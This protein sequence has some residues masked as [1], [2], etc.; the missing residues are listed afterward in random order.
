[1]VDGRKTFVGSPR[2]LVAFSGMGTPNIFETRA[3]HRLRFV[4]YLTPASDPTGADSLFGGDL[5][6]PSVMESASRNRV[7]GRT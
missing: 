5:C 6:V 3:C 4:Y 2:P 1:M 7:E